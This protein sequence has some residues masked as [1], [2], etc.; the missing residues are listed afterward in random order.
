LSASKRKRGERNG[1]FG[2]IRFAMSAI[3]LGMSN[4]FIGIRSSMV[5]WLGPLTGR[6]RVSIDTSTRVSI[7]G[8]GVAAILRESSV[9][10][11]DRAHGARY[12]CSKLKRAWPFNPCDLPDV[13]DKKR[14]SR[15]A[16]RIKLTGATI[17]SVRCS[18]ELGTANIGTCDR[19]Y[20]NLSHNLLSRGHKEKKREV[21]SF[22]ASSDKRTV[23][24]INKA[25]PFGR[26]FLATSNSY[27]PV[28]CLVRRKLYF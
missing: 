10:W 12:A 13:R 4:T 28:I 7:A 1:G 14:R 24:K 17:R 9:S 5:T 8:I 27:G 23:R 21:L 25:G 16:Q 3:S 19:S 11:S 22:T 2:N 26:W 18:A 20:L 6:T 15:Y